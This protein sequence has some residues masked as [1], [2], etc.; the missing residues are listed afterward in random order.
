MEQQLTT[1]FLGLATT[2]AAV[3]ADIPPVVL[4]LTYPACFV[5]GFFV[6]QWHRRH[7]P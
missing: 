3:L 4:L 6:G 2:L 5:I 1:L 7:D